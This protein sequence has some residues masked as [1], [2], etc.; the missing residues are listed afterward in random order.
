MRLHELARG[1]YGRVYLWRDRM[2]A[3]KR[4]SMLDEHG[5][6]SAVILR[7]IQVLRQLQGH[8][9]VTQLISASL[10]ENALFIE[11][12]ILPLNLKSLLTEPLSS[13]LSRKYLRD[14]L[15]GVRFCHQHRIVHRD[16]KPENLMIGFDGV[17]KLA[18]F[19]L[20]RHEFAQTDK[21]AAYTPQMVTLWYRAREILVDGSY[22]RK[23]DIWSV[24]CVF[25]EMLTARVLFPGQSELEMILRIDKFLK[26]VH[27]ADCGQLDARQLDVGKDNAVIILKCFAKRENRPH[28]NEL[29]ACV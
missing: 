17:M 19:G 15:S 3:V 26:S 2:T 16:L 24:G 4:V 6:I 22:D 1:A 8:P 21:E 9:N 18:D 23:I 27:D 14:I 13:T 12:E 29:L 25:A 28:A 7:E 11:M 10:A 20:S 5:G